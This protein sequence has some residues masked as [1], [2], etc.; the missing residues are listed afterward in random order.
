MT[1]SEAYQKSVSLLIDSGFSLSRARLEARLLLD[2]V[3][4]VRH[5]H[6][7]QPERVLTAREH[8]ELL[9]LCMELRSCQPSA[10]LTRQ[11]EFFGLPFRCDRRALIP[12]PETE[13][14]VELAAARL[15]NNSGALIADLGTGSGCIAV[16]MAHAVPGSVVYATD[17][18]PGALD[19][20]RENAALNHVANRIEFVAGRTSK[21]ASPLLREGFGRHVRLRAKQSALYFQIGHRNA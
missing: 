18:S 11:R 19:L 3:C 4:G 13:I 9:H 21:W 20:A 2:H 10:Y 7:L 17:L 1:T 15:R 6:L 12:R 16:S 8:E 5:A 14:L